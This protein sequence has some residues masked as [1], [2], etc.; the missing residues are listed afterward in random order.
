MKIAY[1]AHPISGDVE[2]NLAKI[3]KIVRAINIE[4]PDT[5]PFVPYYADCVSMDDSDPTERARGIKNDEAILRSGI[6]NELRLYGSRV[7]SGMCAEVVN[8]ARYGISIVAKTPETQE[9]LINRK[10]GNMMYKVTFYGSEAIV[11]DR[12][13][14]PEIFDIDFGGDMMVQFK[15]EKDGTIKPINA[16]DGWGDNCFERVCNETP[17]FEEINQQGGE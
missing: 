6:V 1:I 8:A 12:D 2:G 9:W 10:G 17:I 14:E 5:V 11:T 15:R 4:E 3:R 16:M 13:I 7:S